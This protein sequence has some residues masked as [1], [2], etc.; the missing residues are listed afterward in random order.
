M[1]KVFVSVSRG[2]SESVKDKYKNIQTQDNCMFIRISTFTRT[3][4]CSAVCSEESQYSLGN[5]DMSRPG[6]CQ[7][8]RGTK[9]CTLNSVQS[10]VWLTGCRVQYGKKCSEYS[11]AFSVESTVWLTVCRIQYHLQ[12]TEYCIAYSV[13]STVSLTVLLTVFRVRQCLHCAEYII[14]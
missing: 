7:Y 4:Q 11:K 13:Q 1:Q 2:S 8:I 12:Y 9:V 6:I 10:T 3:F 14:T 5:N